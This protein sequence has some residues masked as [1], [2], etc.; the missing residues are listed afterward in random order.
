[1]FERVVTALAVTDENDQ[2][3]EMEGRADRLVFATTSPIESS[4][5]ALGSLLNPKKIAVTR[6]IEEDEEQDSSFWGT[7]TLRVVTRT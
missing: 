1:M 6:A 3:P 5:L 4:E 2:T 7:T